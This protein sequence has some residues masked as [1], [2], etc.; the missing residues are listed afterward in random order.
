M[1]ENKVK[2][3]EAQIQWIQRILDGGDRVELI[4]IRDGVRV[5]HVKRKEIKCE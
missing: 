1:T 2:L 3:S 5:I 4:P